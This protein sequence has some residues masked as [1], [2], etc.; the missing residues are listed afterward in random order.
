VGLN[1]SIALKESLIHDLTGVV[2]NRRQPKIA[3]CS[4]I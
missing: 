4:E 3:E 1:A 2:R